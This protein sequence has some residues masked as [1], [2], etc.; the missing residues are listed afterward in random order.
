MGSPKQPS[1]GHP[2]LL[3][4]YFDHVYHQSRNIGQL[5]RKNRDKA[6]GYNKLVYNRELGELLSHLL[7]SG[8]L[9]YLTQSDPG[10]TSLLN[11]EIILP[12]DEFRATHEKKKG[13]ISE[14]WM[15]G[16]EEPSQNHYDWLQA[17]LDW[18]GDPAELEREEDDIDK[19]DH[20]AMYSELDDYP[21]DMPDLEESDS[22]NTSVYD[23]L[24]ATL[25]STTI[26]TDTE[27]AS[28]MLNVTIGPLELPVSQEANDLVEDSND[29]NPLVD[30][31]KVPAEI[32][33]PQESLP[34][35]TWLDPR[36]FMAE[37]KFKSGWR[38]LPPPL[39]LRRQIDNPDSW[40]MVL[41]AIQ[42]PKVADTPVEVANP[43]NR[44]P[45]YL[46][47]DAKGIRP[48]RSC[49][50]GAG[51]NPALVAQDPG[52]A[53]VSFTGVAPGLGMKPIQRRVDRCP[54]RTGHYWAP[55]PVSRDLPW[56][57]VTISWNLRNRCGDWQPEMPQQCPNKP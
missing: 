31:F 15:C 9:N 44:D 32:P 40:N 7:G 24:Q 5:T 45:L 46:D 33:T 34:T 11:P 47:R 26:S 23:W 14:P 22:V 49:K 57:G 25:A 39:G 48:C 50:K 42:T 6:T 38:T 37:A 20:E 51:G 4:Q 43:Q 53:V 18:N 8:D 16:G 27:A 17:C 55:W 35:R 52:Q 28:D 36:A 3:G 21:A 41:R 13:W 2:K 29:D 30:M 56:T 19:K 12:K 10:P 54:W 1:Y